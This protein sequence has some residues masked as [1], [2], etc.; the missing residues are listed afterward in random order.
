MRVRPFLSELRLYFA[1]HVVSGIPFHFVRKWYYRKLMG[2]ELR[3]GACIHLGAFFY[4]AKGLTM[5]PGS[6]INGRCF[7]D[8]RGGVTIGQ[9][10]T[11]AM[12]TT[13]LTADHDV[14]T[15]RLD[16]RER[17]VIIEDFVFIGTGATIMPGV[18]IGRAAAVAA[19]AVVTKDVP[20]NAVVAGV[21]ARVIGMRPDP[22]EDFTSEY[23]R[24]FH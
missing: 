8:T 21:P 23:V 2:F 17:P 5:G 7:I 1:N 14:K 13:V 24:L 16:S 11:L 22:S 6:V 12:Q 4:A 3:E 9:H 20:A 19:R 18:R 10:V 15:P